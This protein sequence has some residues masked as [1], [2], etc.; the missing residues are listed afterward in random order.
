VRPDLNYYGHFPELKL[1]HQVMRWTVRAFVKTGVDSSLGYKLFG[2]FTDAGLPEPF[3]IT[4]TVM[5]GRADWDGFQVRADATKS[6]MPLF[7]EFGIATSDEVGPDTLAQRLCAEAITARL[8]VPY[9]TYV[10]AW[11]TKR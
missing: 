3:M 5:G 2:I 7:E 1:H 6:L 10:G 9:G 4:T 11:T 8:P